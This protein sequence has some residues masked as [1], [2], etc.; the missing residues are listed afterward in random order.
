MTLAST[1]SGGPKS[2]P[3]ISVRHRSYKNQERSGGLVTGNGYGFALV[4]KDGAVSKFFAHPYRF[5]RPSPDITANG[6]ETANFLHKLSFNDGPVKSHAYLSESH[7]IHVQAQESQQFFFMPFGLARNALIALRQSN[8]ASVLKPEWKH[9]VASRQVRQ[10]ARR[11]VHLLNFRGIKESLAII[12]LTE[13]SSITD[14]GFVGP[15]WALLVIEDESTL[16]AAVQDLAIWQDGRTMEALL[17]AELSELEAWRATTYVRFYS[18]DEHK[19]WRQSE[20]VLRMAQIREPNTPTRNSDGLIVASLPDGEWFIPWVRDMAYAIVALTRM[21]HY[22]E[23]RR[24]LLAY[25]NARPTG[26]WKSETRNYDYQISV[27]R[28][29]GDGTEEADYSGEATPNIELDNFG[30]VLWALTDHCEYTQDTSWLLTPTFRGTVYQSARDY[31][32]HPLLSN[33]D[34]WQGGSIVAADSS[35]WEEHQQNK[36]HFA[37]A[38]I[39]AIA[40]LRAFLKVAVAAGDNT[41]Q[42]NIK[43]GLRWLERGFPMAF[44][45]PD[46]L[47]GSLEQSYKNEIDGAVLEAF[48]FDIV[49]D[50]TV[51]PQ[52]LAK[53]EH[54][55]TAAGGFRRVRGDTDYE[56]QE[57]LFVNFNLARA[58]FKQNRSSEAQMILQPMVDRASRTN[59]LL[60]E[61][62]VSEKN[63]EFPGNVGDPAGALPMVGYGAAAYILTL[64]D[65]E[66]SRGGW[67]EKEFPSSDLDQ[68][69][70]NTMARPN[71]REES[72]IIAEIVKATIDKQRAGHKPGQT[73]RRDVHTKSHGTYK[74]T[75]SVRPDV[76]A[77]LKVG[78]FAKP[79][80]YKALARF[81]NG[82]F[83]VDGWDILPNIRGLAIKILDVP[84]KKVIPGEENSTEHDILLA[85]DE[86]FFVEKIEQMLLL[87]TGKFKDI[88]T[89]HHRVLGGMLK[90]MFKLMK[91]PLHSQYFSQV[92]YQ[93]GT[94]ACKYRLTPV[95]KASFF[96]LPNG[97]DR[98]YLRNGINSILT[99]R[100]LQFTLSVQLQ[101]PAVD[102]IEDSSIAWKGAYVPVADL[103]FHMVS[104]PVAESQGEELSF[105]PTRALPEHQ[106]L[107]WPGRV[108]RE[109]YAADFQWRT[110]QNRK[111]K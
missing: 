32:V 80:C 47:A 56:K 84:G 49:S 86:V 60:P 11:D 62:Y 76:P 92:P 44:I 23:A 35:C 100:P 90:A 64:I 83:G 57:F 8:V 105:N 73:A 94:G 66:H 78:L 48:N 21:G 24:A 41:T 36:K 52:T 4:S 17:Q 87:S 104:S 46:G 14:D 74:A 110:E 61:M 79:G 99:K 1:E 30:L 97:L 71:S 33:V 7:I 5:E 15:A 6:V 37:S 13:G 59:W 85:N 89:G 111:S 55:R 20:T 82:A 102:S 50:K 28:Y 81:S 93:F 18:T 2:T 101:D 95:E 19:L 63:D 27:V 45:R 109:V 34:Q 25:F 29:Y 106:P 53:M 96:S 88:L 16:D 68:K 22:D 67:T 54:L 43:R 9:A 98:H 39:A 38:T 107:G 26:L 51:F 40:G 10:I 58:L 72:A 42:N 91:N 75:F 103:T 70:D 65:R 12:P 77:Q 108:R 3:S 69:G 31:I